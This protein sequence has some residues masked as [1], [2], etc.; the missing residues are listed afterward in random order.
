MTESTGLVIINILCTFGKAVDKMKERY[1]PA[2]M[3]L[4]KFQPI[5]IIVTSGWFDRDWQ[6]TG[7]SFGGG[8]F[9]DAPSASTDPFTTQPDP[10]VQPDPPSTQVTTP[11]TTW[12]PNENEGEIDWGALDGQGDETTMPHSTAPSDPFEETVPT[13]IVYE[14]NGTTWVPRENEGAMDWGAFDDQ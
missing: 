5:D 11:P 1:L 8:S 12:I 4:V 2:K 3:E 6:L 7:E 13:T 14:D 9:G 10:T